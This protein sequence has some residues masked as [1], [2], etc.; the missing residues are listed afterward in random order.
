[1]PM[2]ALDDFVVNVPDLEQRRARPPMCHP[3]SRTG[4]PCQDAGC[5]QIMERAVDGHARGAKGIRQFRLGRYAIPLGPRAAVN[6]GEHEPFDPLI[7]RAILV[8]PAGE[9]EGML[10]APPDLE[11]FH[12]ALT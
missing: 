8:R 6:L 7:E 9:L 3:G 12:H 4:T 5:R 1:M 2:A 10:A 11:G